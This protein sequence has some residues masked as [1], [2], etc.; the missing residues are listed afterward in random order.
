MGIN[1]AEA[2]KEMKHNTPT[3]AIGQVWVARLLDKR[4]A[5]RIRILGEYPS[6][7]ELNR[8]SE[9]PLWIYEELKGGF[10]LDI[11]RL[12]LCPEL[13]LRLVFRP[14]QEST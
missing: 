5:R 11:G 14:E 3:I 12:G 9:Y 7:G 10:K 4:A 13:N 2:K 6:G 8:E 1:V